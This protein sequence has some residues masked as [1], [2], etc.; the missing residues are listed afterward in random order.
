MLG[1]GDASGRGDE[2]AAVGDAGQRI[3]AAG[4]FGAQFDVATVGNVAEDCGEAD[5]TAGTEFTDADVDRKDLAVL[6]AAK[7]VAAEAENLGAAGADV[8]AHIA[9]VAR[10]EWFGHQIGRA[11]CRER[12]CQYV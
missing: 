4:K 5:V 11:S 2:T 1:A 7:R 3:V 8:I 6:L 12:V 10:A 9:V